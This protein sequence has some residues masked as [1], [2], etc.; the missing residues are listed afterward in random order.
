MRA[1]CVAI[2]ETRATVILAPS[3]LGRLLG[4]RPVRC[5]LYRS[6]H[7]PGATWESLHTRRPIWELP[8]GAIIREA[9]ELQTI[10][11]LP[12]AAVAEEIS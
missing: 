3:W 9:L 4:A 6:P 2:S 11:D 1:R 5:E 12:V 8:H 10:D 7:V